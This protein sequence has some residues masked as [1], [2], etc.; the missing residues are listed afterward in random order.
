MVACHRSFWG[1][2]CILFFWGLS[3]HSKNS[4]AL[5]FQSTADRVIYGDDDRKDVYEV[6]TTWQA[7]ASS[8]VAIVMGHQVQKTASGYKLETDHYGSVWQ[9]CKSEPFYNQTYGSFCSAS[10]IAP[11][12][13]LT[14]GHCVKNLSQCQ[15]SRYVFNYSHRSQNGDPT[16]LGEDD[17]Y[18]CKELIHSQYASAD[19]AIVRLDRKVKGYAPLGINRSSGLKKG[20]GLVLIGNPA[21]LPTKVA[22]GARV[23][24]NSPKGYFIGDTDSYGGNS[25]S[26]VFNSNTGLIEGILVRGSQDFVPTAQGCYKSNYCKGMSDCRGE[27]IT[28]I[29]EVLSYLPA[30]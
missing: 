3:A 20:D 19:F 8:T 17:V 5:A 28:R 1:V 16:E 14:A 9:L 24:D 29:E 30:N 27:D 25:G 22:A 15:E 6:D 13:I 21:G 10:L 26:A 2:V 11:D 4:E 18:S 12:L 23:L 7:R